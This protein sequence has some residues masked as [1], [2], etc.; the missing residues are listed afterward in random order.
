MDILKALS[1]QNSEPTTGIGQIKDFVSRLKC[2]SNPESMLQNM[3]AQR[4][5]AMAKAI[6]YVNQCGG[7]PKAAFQK[8][9][10]EQGIDASEIETM[11]R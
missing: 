4:N 1:A 2:M 10:Q 6:D 11:F 8:L 9:A 5:P 7:D 3:L